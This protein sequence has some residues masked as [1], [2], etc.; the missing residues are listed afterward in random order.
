MRA[1]D[2]KL[3][4]EPAPF[5]AREK[6]TAF[7]AHLD[8]CERCRTQPFNLCIRGLALLVTAGRVAGRHETGKDQ[9]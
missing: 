3:S 5:P 1:S 7:H 8:R 9:L 6:I 4:D 2:E